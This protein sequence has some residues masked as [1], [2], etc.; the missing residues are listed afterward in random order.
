[1]RLTFLFA[2]CMLGPSFVAEVANY[3]LSM[4]VIYGLSGFCLICG[5]IKLKEKYYGIGSRLS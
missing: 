5:L 2:F 1:M 3:K 4:E